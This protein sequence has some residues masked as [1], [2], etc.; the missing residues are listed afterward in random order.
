[1][2]T[3]ISIEQA[4][5]LIAQLLASPAL[6][7]QRLDDPRIEAI[8]K[9]WEAVDRTRFHLHNWN[10]PEIHNKPNFDLVRLWSEA[11][12][13]IAVFD[14]ELAVRLRR[15]AEH[16]GNPEH[17]S[18]KEVSDAGIGIDKVTEDARRLLNFSRS[19]QP[20]AETGPT[21]AVE[22]EEFD[23]FISHA[24]EDK[25]DIASPLA[26]ELSKRRYKV[27]YDDYQLELGDNL[28]QEIDKGLL[29]CRYGVVI[30][31]HKFFSK[32]WTRRE[33]DSLVALEDSDG[34]KRIIPVLHHMKHQE[35]AAYSPI[36]AARITASS[37]Q[38]IESLANEIVRVLKK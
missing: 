14:N 29:S 1:M 28:R 20:V 5:P 17:W 35:V 9:V 26:F 33:L 3:V 7:P 37:E 19:P 23:V 8:R 22:N 25:K 30:L 32:A 16:W 15:K 12:L 27:W 10:D 36:I 4:I 18:D 13:A 11:A 2:D 21:K 24:S 6:Q 34:R 31:S 38:G